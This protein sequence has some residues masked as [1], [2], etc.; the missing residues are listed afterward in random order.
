MTSP[1]FN[2]PADHGSTVRIG[3]VS[4]LNTKPLVHGLQ[5]LLPEAEIIY[6][7]PS[8]LAD[9]L[10]TGKLDVYVKGGSYSFVL[11][12]A[13]PTGKGSLALLFEKWKKEFNEK[14]YFS[15]EIKK[16]IKNNNTCIGILII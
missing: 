14:G 11:Y 1:A 13:K 6:D 3:A 10:A 9:E 5:E 8:R 4:Y 7:L 15:P 16:Q 2:P 12:T